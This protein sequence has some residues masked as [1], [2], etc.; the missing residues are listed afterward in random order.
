MKKFNHTVMMLLSIFVFSSFTTVNNNAGKITNIENQIAKKEIDQPK[1]I[2]EEKKISE[3]IPTENEPE[4]IEEGKGKVTWYGA[5]L[6]GRFMANG[7]RF[8]KD[9]LTC[10][11]SWDPVTKT[12]EFPFGT[13][14]KITNLDN[15]KSVVVTVTDTG[16]FAKH[17]IKFDLSEGAFEQIGKLSKGV[18]HIKY[19]VI[20]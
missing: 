18:L 7:E 4:I 19:E 20:G 9:E 6:H 15:N 16:A 8:D 2:N 11:T 3:I 5:K 17:G 13:K 14:I 1:S 10:A 12:K